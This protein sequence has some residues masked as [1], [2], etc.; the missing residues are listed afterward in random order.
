MPYEQLF[1]S[2]STLPEAWLEAFQALVAPRVNA[3]VPLSVTIVSENGVEVGGGRNLQFEQVLDEELSR[4]GCN[5]VNTTANTIF[6][7]SMWDPTRERSNLY[8]RYHQILPRI[9]RLDPANRNGIYFERMI[10]F[11]TREGMQQNQEPVN[12]L[13][14]IITTFHRGNHRRSALQAA[15]FSPF[16]DHSHQRQRGFPCLQHVFF[17]PGGN[18]NEL[19][20]TGVYATQYMFDRG[21]G[22]YLGLLRLGK[23]MASELDLR[24]TQVTIT[25]SH[26]KQGKIGKIEGRELAQRLNAILR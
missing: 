8:D 16:D 7:Q 6:P 13:E 25:A 2:R 24:L 10:S 23:F 11:Q 19:A 4:R 9:K 5:S 12:Q 22:N 20:I 21:Y 26:A 3:I 14:H 15:I 17:T 1:I 18:G